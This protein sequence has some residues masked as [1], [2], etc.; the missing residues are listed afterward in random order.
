MTAAQVQKARKLRE[1]G[2]TYAAI[3]EKL[4]LAISI[5][6]LRSAIIGTTYAD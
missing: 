1:S 4:G 6:A 5:P 3:K 2:E